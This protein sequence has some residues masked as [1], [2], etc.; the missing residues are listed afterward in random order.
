M[1]FNEFRSVEADFLEE[2]KGIFGRE[3]GDKFVH[4]DGR[5][6]ELVEVLSFPQPDDNNGQFVDVAARDEAIKAFEEQNKN[7]IEW[8]NSPANNLLAFGVA[9]LD[10]LDGN[11]V[12]WGKYVQRILRTQMRN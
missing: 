4:L 11:H 8:V 5:E 9:V 1:R 7:T 2:S 3:A 6:W 12:L 10:D